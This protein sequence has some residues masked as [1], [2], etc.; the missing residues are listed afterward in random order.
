MKYFWEF[1]IFCFLNLYQ[2]GVFLGVFNEFL[3]YQKVLF[4][5]GADFFFFKYVN[6]LR[7]LNFI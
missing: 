6:F 7:K 4:F 3:L 2:N 5:M 1:L